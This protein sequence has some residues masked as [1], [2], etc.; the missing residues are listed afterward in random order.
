EISVGVYLLS[1]I[2]ASIATFLLLLVL[3]LITRG[4]VDIVLSVTRDMATA[5]HRWV[6]FFTGLLT[7]ALGIIILQQPVA[8]SEAF[9][10]ALGLYGIISGSIDLAMANSTKGH[11]NLK[12]A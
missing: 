11:T 12:P 7:I 10:W 5:T 6:T 2:Y 4:A 8:G 9:V 3:V 1:H